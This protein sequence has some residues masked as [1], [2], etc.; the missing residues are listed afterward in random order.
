MDVNNFDQQIEELR[1]RVRGI[2][3]RTATQPNSHQ[4]LIIEAFDELQIAV[5]EL[6]AAS[7]ELEETRVAVEK[8][9]QRYQEL[10]DF[11]P[12]AYL[13]T[14]ATGK[15]LEANNVAATMF[16]MALKYLVGKPLILFIA[17]QDRQFFR[18]QIN[19]PRQIQDWVI[20]LKPRF[21]KPF[22]ASI[23]TSPVYDSQ[24]KLVSWRWLL[25]NISEAKQAQERV[26]K[27]T[28]DLAKANEQLLSEITERK[29]AESQL[30]HLALHDV[31][32]GL[33][34][35]TLFMNRLKDAVD[36]SKRHSDYLFA[37]LFIDLDHFKLINDSLGH[38]LGDQ[39][40]FTV[41]QR[42]QECLRSVDIAARLGG[43]EFIILL[44][45]I[46]DVL[47]VVAVVKR[48]QKKLALPVVLG[49]QEVSTTASIGIA[50]SITGCQQPEDF[51]RD[52]DIAM[53]RAK[54][55]GRACYEI[56][57][58]DMHIQAMAH[59]ELVNEL[60]RAIELQ[61]FQVYY[62]PIVSLSSGRIT[63]FEALVRWL[64]PKYGIVL[65][66]YF[67]STAQETGL[68][69]LI[70]QWVLYEACSQIQ[71]WQEQFFSN[72]KGLPESPLSISINLCSTRFS[73]EKLLP[74]I[75]KVLQDTGLSAP[76]LTLEITESVIMENDDKAIIRLKQLRNLGIKL[77]IDDFG[78]GYSSLGRLHHFP[79]NQLKIDR[80]FVSGSIFDHGNLDIVQTIIT[81][82]H[83]L[84]VDVTAE[85]V[86][87]EEQLAM[88]RNLSC[89]YGQ[90]YF[91]SHPLD[92][93]E[94]ATLIMANPQW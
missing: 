45:G 63:G 40:L 6:L 35:R 17:Q 71:Q 5:E 78:T 15:I 31:L 9:R 16:C 85:G 70:E 65:P 86:E 28:E 68:I 43:D 54:T 80:S 94:A 8:E 82:A 1:S 61:E 84:S 52:A 83:K 91:F 23:R 81:L 73:E 55:Q 47:E 22:P 88:L 79:I 39:L 32:T 19:N 49:G 4:E 46:K 60:R 7:E 18:S 72:S 58:T 3:Q 41:A 21:N 24:K 10:F 89:E 67:M 76:S 38:A 56:F 87:T 74:H 53:Y 69:I 51:L 59:L 50:L 90:G 57:N 27:R 64:H 93:S 36:Y 66:E 25:R 33:P 44:V 2:W 42:L 20:D 13:V 12:D 77:A 48:I 75:N 11:A 92:S 14:D 62:Q 29:R 30:L 37:V 26:A 34:N